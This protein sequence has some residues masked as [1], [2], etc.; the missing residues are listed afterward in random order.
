IAP[1]AAATIVTSL[2]TRAEFHA[3]GVFVNP[4]HEE[5]DD[6]LAVCDLDLI[7]LSGDEPP[8]LVQAMPRPT[9]KAIHVRAGEEAYAAHVV[10]RD[11]YTAHRYLLDTHGALPGGNGIAFDWQ[12][13]RSVGGRCL[14]AG[15]L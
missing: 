1:A 2:R 6:A 13:L 4:S 11:P 15:G 8:D 10:E 12:A 3:V 7:Q 5:V 14:V 9:V